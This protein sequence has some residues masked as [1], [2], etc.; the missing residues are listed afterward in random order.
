MP[1]TTLFRSLGYVPDFLRMSFA[2]GGEHEVDPELVSAL[3]LLLILHADHEQNCSAST[4]RI[5]GSAQA[6]IYASVA[7]GIGALSG[8]LHGGAN[9]AVLAMLNEI[10]DSDD[11]VDTFMN[12][13]KN[14]EKG[15]RLM[16]D[17]KSVV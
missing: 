13:V 10:H 14:K 15:V 1:Y 5:V 17:R 7:A 11:D 6:N 4:V 9:E 16:G 8:P 3:N 2:N 12:R